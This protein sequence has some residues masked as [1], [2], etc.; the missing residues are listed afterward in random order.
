MKIKTDLVKRIEKHGPLTKVAVKKSI[1]GILHVYEHP[2]Y[3]DEAPLLVFDDLGIGL[4]NDFYEPDDIGDYDL[5]AADTFQYAAKRAAVTREMTIEDWDNLPT[6][7]TDLSLNLYPT[8]RREGVGIFAPEGTCAQ[9]DHVD[10]V[11]EV[12]IPPR[13]SIVGGEAITIRIEDGPRSEP[14]EELSEPELIDLETAVQ[15]EV[16]LMAKMSAL[17][18]SMTNF[19]LSV[20]NGELNDPAKIRAQAEILFCSLT[21]MRDYGPVATPRTVK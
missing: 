21:L 10:G 9:I 20:A 13:P 18:P 2:V 14:P 12:V 16:M 5:T 1:Y 3:G 4:P 17:A 15:G 8:Y 6:K 11:I 7:D 19:V